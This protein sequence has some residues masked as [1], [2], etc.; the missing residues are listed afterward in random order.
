VDGGIGQLHAAA[1][2]LQDLQIINQPLAS[3]A[4][5]EEILYVHGRESEPVVFDHHSPVL[6]LIQQIRDEAHRFAVTFHRARR[7]R[8][9]LAS[10]LLT[11]P[12]VGERTVKKLL[13]HFGSLSNLKSL[14]LEELCQVVTRAQA[15]RIVE[16]FGG[17]S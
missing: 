10:E 8:R 17:K 15:A 9:E 3:I 14:T 6:H 4:K 5:R 11:I 12:G 7:A 1:G 16:H 2:A 13:A